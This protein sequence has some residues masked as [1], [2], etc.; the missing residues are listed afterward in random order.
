MDGT[1]EVSHA[2]EIASRRIHEQPAGRA[3]L[4]RPPER[5]GRPGGR[6]G[7]AG[8]A[9]RP[10]SRAR[11]AGAA[12]GAVTALPGRK[13]L[14]T[15]ELRAARA[16]PRGQPGA[17]KGRRGGEGSRRATG[18]GPRQPPAGRAGG[19]EGSGPAAAACLAWGAGSRAPAPAAL[20]PPRLPGPKGNTTNAPTP[21]LLAAAPPADTSAV[22][23]QPNSVYLLIPHY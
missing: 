1:I 13:R 22:P 7:R 11:V 5:Q 2:A 20:S 9:S 12:R 15:P 10:C 17:V 23:P 3:A 4:S 8:P 19:G 14:R 16:P 18:A 6:S 21:R